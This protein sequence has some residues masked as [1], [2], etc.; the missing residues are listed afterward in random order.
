[1][2]YNIAQIVLCAVEL[3]VPMIWKNAV[4]EN[5]VANTSLGRLNERYAT[6]LI[7]HITIFQ[8]YALHY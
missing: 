2:H 3:A 6:M 7:K 4:S 5:E 1:L 8:T